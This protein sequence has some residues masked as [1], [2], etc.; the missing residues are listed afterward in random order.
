MILDIKYMETDPLL[1]LAGNK[2]R[3]FL[4]L[5]GNEVLD[6]VGGNFI[7]ASTAFDKLPFSE[8]V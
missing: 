4:F 1:F 7:S 8:R 5:T 3:E 6:E 2:T